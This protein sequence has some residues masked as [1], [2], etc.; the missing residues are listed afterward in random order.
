MTKG[1]KPNES[2]VAAWVRFY[3]ERAFPE[4]L[5]GSEQ[6][7]SDADPDLA[8]AQDQAAPPDPGCQSQPAGNVYKFPGLFSRRNRP[9][10]DR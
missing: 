5:E 2:I 8:H 1:Q 10:Q 6:T 4:I 7:P 3:L 9:K